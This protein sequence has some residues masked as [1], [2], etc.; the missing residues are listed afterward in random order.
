MDAEK[1]FAI[2][3]GLQDIQRLTKKMGFV[4]DM[5]PGIIAYRL[6]PIDVR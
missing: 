1:S 2:K 6:N 3:P 4:S 5:K